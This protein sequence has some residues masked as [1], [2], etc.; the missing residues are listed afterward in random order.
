MRVGLGIGALTVMLLM[1]VAGS[2]G[3]HPERHAF[4]PDGS[5]G[6]VPPVRAKSDQILTVC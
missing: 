5:V 2:A 6:A 1:V 4:F 3:A